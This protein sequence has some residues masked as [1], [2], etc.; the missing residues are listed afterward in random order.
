MWYLQFVVLSRLIRTVS[1]WLVLTYYV[2]HQEMFKHSDFLPLSYFYRST[3]YQEG[4]LYSSRAK[5]PLRGHWSV[6][7]CQVWVDS[8]QINFPSWPVML[9]AGGITG[10]WQ[11]TMT[12][13]M[14]IS[15]AVP[16]VPVAPRRLIEHSCRWCGDTGRMTGHGMMT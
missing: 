11:P 14:I 15:V 4:A 3:E 5:L 13:R 9:A 1:T 8:F 2:L 16:L 10:R 7:Q 6:H 12:W